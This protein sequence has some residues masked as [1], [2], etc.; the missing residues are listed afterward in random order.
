MDQYG[1]DDVKAT[2][3]KRLRKEETVTSEK[4]SKE[5]N[6]L[7]D[8][9]E[10]AG[11]AEEIDRNQLFREISSQVSVWQPDPSVLRDRKHK[12]WLPERKTEINWGFWKRYRQYLEEEKN[13]PPVVTGKLDQVTD[14]TLGDIGNPAQSGAWDRRGMVVGD[15][16]SGKTANYTGL[17]CKAVDAGYKL[18]IVLAGMTNDLRSQTQSRLDAEF[19][20]FES[21][22]GKFHENGSRIGVGKIEDHGQ[23]IVQ[24]LTYSAHGGDFRSRKGTNSQLGGNP[25]LLV[26]KKN[27]SVLNRILTWVEGQGQT[28]PETGEKVVNGIPLLLLDDEADNASVNTKDPEEDP[29]AINRAIRKI[30]KTFSQSSYIGYT[31]TPFAN[32]F[33][34]P[35]DEESE[36]SKYGEDLFPRNFIY[37]INPPDN[38][39]G[40]T[41]V[42]GLS[43]SIDGLAPVD[44]SLPL[45]RHA[46][47]AEQYFPAK[48][49]KHLPVEGLPDTMI[50]AIRAFVLS[51]AARRVRGQKNVHN[52]MLIHVTRFNDVQDKVIGL[53]GDELFSIQR[54]L[55]FNT[56][57]QWKQLLEQLKTLW[58]NDFVVKTASIMELTGDPLITPIQWSE[59]SREL[60]EAALKI[61]VRGINGLAE[62]VLDYAEHPKGLNVI[63]VGGDK[64]SRGLTL[65]GL[66]VSYY[67]RPARN[68]DTLLQMGRWFGYRPGYLD[69]C[70]LYTTEE[71][72]GWYQHIAVATEE[73]KREFKL[74]ELSNLTPEAYGL[75]VRTHANGLSITAANK[76]RSG[77]KMQVTFAD[78]LAQTIVFDKNSKTQENNFRHIDKWISA[79]GSLSAQK[80]NNYLWYGVQSD[81]IHELLAGFKIHPFSRGADPELI[82]QY[83]EKVNDLGELKSWTVALI[84]SGTAKNHHS[85]GGHQTG[86]TERTDAQP[87]SNLYWIRNANIISPED[88]YLDL[89]DDEFKAALA[90]TIDA[91]KRGQTRH[92][93]EPTSPNGPFIRRARNP[94][95]GLLLIYPL[96]PSDVL[97]KSKQITNMPIIGMAMSFPVSGNRTT[98]EYQ[99][100]T[101]YWLDRYGDDEDDV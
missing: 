97:L 75:K 58:E 79:L 65:D 54:T 55:E 92:K 1:Y 3:M 67:T 80:N 41:K 81:Q 31:A 28:N 37:Y 49:K 13:W 53:V 5:I 85:V 66:S 78:S 87:G 94:Q 57:P 95:R 82:S 60:T 48:H 8:A 84:S 21:E 18:V 47:D 15:V 11:L 99:V 14:A 62:G 25:L 69:L 51:C 12:N 17:I 22:L 56:G 6:A 23:L 64:L 101:K 77:K 88:Q 42:F 96:D 29:T 71:I 50:E 59:V 40:A 20:G 44:K 46:E 4:I 9:F 2:V 19:L 100:N 33:I 35:P 26:V 74:M 68:Y 93:E 89:D 91:W 86:L 34:L 45:I 10:A 7:L 16:Q 39:I 70:R 43:E 52:T 32:I 63:A 98:V 72:E 83:I 27:T 61:Q 73:L 36:K 90:N 24:P 76:I 38:Y 30:L